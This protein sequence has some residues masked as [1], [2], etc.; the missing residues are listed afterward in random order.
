[1][2]FQPDQALDRVRVMSMHR[3]KGLS[4]RVVF[5]PGLENGLIPNRRQLAYP[6]QIM[7]AT[8]LLCVSITRARAATRARVNQ[9]IADL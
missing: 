6:A 7:E 2:P 5:I 4:A 1:M 9:A 3:A 8:R